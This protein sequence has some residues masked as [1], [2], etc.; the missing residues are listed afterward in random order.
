MM[1]LFGIF[2]IRKA[3][4]AAADLFFVGVSA[5]IANFILSFH[6][7]EIEEASLVI[8]VAVS[9]I[10]CIGGLMIAGAYSK[11]WR[12]FNRKD[13][14]S[15]IY[16]VVIGIVSSAAIV[17]MISG[18]FYPAFS[19]IHTFILICVICLF[20]YLFKTT[21]ITIAESSSINGKRTMVIGGG[22]ACKTILKEIYNA[23]N[24]PYTDDKQVTAF[25]PVCIIDDNR[26]MIGS[27]IEGVEIVGTTAEIHRFVKDRKIE[28]ILFA[29]P[30]CLE[31]ERK[32]ILDIC[33]DTNLPVKVVP[34][35]MT[36]LPL[37]SER[38]SGSSR[39]DA[40]LT[41]GAM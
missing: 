9:S 23:K 12:Y 35:T 17:Y 27:E 30:S 11:L 36:L 22:Q 19:L 14:L 20:R 40:A 25:D 5:L 10:C 33:T 7:K 21:F 31:D 26:D 2:K 6:G 38:A 39:M 41:A 1:E 8:S 3:V 15:C 37:S 28:Q 18:T 16:G 34:F 32:R 13:Y 4:L 29:I 24:S